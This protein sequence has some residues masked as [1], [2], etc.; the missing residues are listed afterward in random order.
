MN[1]QFLNA[2]IK[3]RY[4]VNSILGKGAFGKIYSA[5]DNE[6][7]IEVALKV[8]N[9]SPNLILRKE[10]DTLKELEGGIGIPRVYDF[11]T[12]NDR[13]IMIFE[14]LGKSLEFFKECPPGRLS[15]KTV[16]MLSQQMITRVQ[17]LHGRGFIHRDIKPDNFTMGLDLRANQVYIIDFGLARRYID[18]NRIHIKFITGK[19]LTGTARYC[20]IWTHDGIEQSRR[21]DMEILGIN[22]IYLLKGSLPWQG[23]PGNTKSEKN[24]NISNWKKRTSIETL[25][26]NLPYEFKDYLRY[27]RTLDFEQTPDYQY[28]K[29]IFKKLFFKLK[30]TFDLE[31]DWMIPKNEEIKDDH[32]NNELSKIII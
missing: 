4:K 27:C 31:F 30:Y 28:L 26:E 6:N 22:M 21:D 11:I 19:K 14:K 13:N 15:L 8:E 29:R 24:S 9:A 20:S 25:C 23:L 3:D 2:T 7:N 12:Y 1:D 5:F 16:L 32:E 18:H 10:Y 17:Y